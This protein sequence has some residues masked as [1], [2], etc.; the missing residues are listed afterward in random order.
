M[1]KLTIRVLGGTREVG[2]SAILLDTG[3]TRVLLD[4]GMKLIPKQHPQFPPMVDEEVDA[5]LLSH[6]HLDHS[7]S[8]PRLYRRGRAPPIYGID[9]TRDYSEIL[10]YDAIKVAK[11]KDHSL[12][13]GADEVRRALNNFRPI[14]Y[15]VPFRVGD[16]EITAYNAGHIPGSAMFYIKY[17]SSTLLYTGDFNTSRSRLMP[18]AD[19]DEIPK[20]DFLITESTYAFKEHPPRDKQ[21][22]LLKNVVLETI[23]ARGTA[24]I[25]GFAIGR[26]LEVAMA[27]KA[28]GYKGRLFLDGMARRS[29]EITE[30]YPE[31]VRDYNEM[32]LVAREITF[33]KNWAMRKKVA[34]RPSVILT[35]SGMIEG[36]P[37]HYYLKEKGEDENSSI[38]L[39]G[40]Q[41]EGTEGRRLLEEGKVEIDGED[42]WILMKVNQ[43]NFSAH[44]SRSG[45]MKL[46]H[47]VRPSGVMVV[48]GEDSEKFANQLEEKEGISAFSPEVDEEVLI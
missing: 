8:I 19:I 48:H 24:I 27:L 29:T 39:T 22:V 16:L 20:T 12:G 6:A 5:I 23:K 30:S 34:K 9:I 42:R 1:S 21:E 28:Q 45:I 44:A 40:Y 11:I 17:D 46:I 31:R 33:V 14:E 37:V 25:A 26:L 43:L 32:A 36:G 13:Y 18:A 4:Y 47:S 2:R 15:G 3:K 10:L 35:T 38:T 7:G 41:I